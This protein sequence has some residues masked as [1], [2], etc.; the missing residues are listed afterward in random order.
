MTGQRF[1]LRRRAYLCSCLLLVVV[2]GCGKSKGTINGTVKY[3]KTPLTSGTIVFRGADGYMDSASISATGEYRLENFPV[4]EAKIT[5]VT[6]RYEKVAPSG[7]PSTP[8]G[9]TREVKGF[10]AI[11]KKYSDPEK[12]GL[13]WTVTKG[14]QEHDIDLD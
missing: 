9:T 3:K 14:P 10:V 1:G 13:T 4:G 6:Q 7:K 8:G 2:A 12:S 5:V 11:P